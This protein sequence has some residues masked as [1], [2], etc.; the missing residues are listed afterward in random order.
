MTVVRSAMS[1]IDGYTMAD[2]VTIPANDEQDANSILI[3]T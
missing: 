2:T 1:G 3:R